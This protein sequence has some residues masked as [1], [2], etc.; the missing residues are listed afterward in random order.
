MILRT[1]KDNRESQ[2]DGAN[3]DID[4]AAIAKVIADSIDPDDPNAEAKIKDMADILVHVLSGGEGEGQ[5]Q[6]GDK[7]AKSLYRKQ[8][9]GVVSRLPI[10]RR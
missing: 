8:A 1:K 2:D 10:R 3:P 4:E 6:G 5:G 9:K 7:G